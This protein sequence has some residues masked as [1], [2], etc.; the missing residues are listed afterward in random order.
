MTMFKSQRANPV[1]CSEERMPQHNM[2]EL[3]FYVLGLAFVI[4]ATV[5]AVV[6]ILCKT[7]CC[8]FDAPILL[9]PVSVITG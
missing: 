9:K 5:I 2:A 8:P 6:I 7:T 1:A 4:M 3:L